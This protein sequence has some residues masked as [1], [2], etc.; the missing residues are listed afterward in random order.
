MSENE[1]LTQMNQPID[2]MIQLYLYISKCLQMYAEASNSKSTS[3]W[4]REIFIFQKALRHWMGL[5]W[6]QSFNKKSFF[7][8]LLA[9]VLS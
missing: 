9:N 2:K 5:K 1:R 7:L 6:R 3:K 8:T 4:S